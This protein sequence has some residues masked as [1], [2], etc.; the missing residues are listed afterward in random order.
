M[1]NGGLSYG[2]KDRHVVGHVLYEPV[3][4]ENN[5]MCFKEPHVTEWVRS[6]LKAMESAGFI[7]KCKAT[8]VIAC[9]PFFVVDNLRKLRLVYDARGNNHK[10]RPDSFNLPGPMTPL[11]NTSHHWYAK[12]DLTNAFYSIPL[13]P[14]M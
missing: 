14:D 4:I 2:P 9:L 13:A 7:K 1:D 6:E 3:R 10:F 12:T 5:Q 11:L 8:D